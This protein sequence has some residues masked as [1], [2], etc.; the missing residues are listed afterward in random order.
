MRK[1]NQIPRRNFVKT[2]AKAMAILPF[3]PVLSS[4][5]PSNKALKQA[6]KHRKELIDLLENLIRVQ[7]IEG[8]SAANAQELVKKYLSKLPYLIEE[9]ADRPSLYKEHPEYMTPNPAGDGPFTNVVGWPKEQNGKQFAM[10]SHI[11][12]H[13]IEKGWSTD[14]FEPKII[15]NKFYGLGTSDDKAGVAA[16]LVSAT[17]LEKMGKPLPVVMS[18]HGKGGGGRGSLPVFERIRNTDHNLNAILYVHPAETGRGLDDIKNSVQG[19]ADLQLQMSGWRGTPLEIG[20]VDSAK[21]DDGGSAVDQCLELLE[22]LRETVYKDVLVNIGIIDGGDRIG[23][24]ADKVT[25]TFR[26][27]FSGNHTW[28][29]LVDDSNK[30]IKEFVAAK[31]TA[32]NSYTF[33]LKSVGYM[34]NPGAADWESTESKILRSSIT[35]IM[36]KEPTAYPNHYA[37]DIRYPI[38]LLGIPAYGIGSLGGNFYLPDEWVDID[39]LV[40]L[41]AVLVDTISG[42]GNN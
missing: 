22:I 40:K 37:G 7:S 18:L 27:K 21:W 15:G 35:D 31:S 23:S 2:S 36:G 17:I 28:K 8:E 33:E 1:E 24:V 19:I 38:R 30:V 26:L 10:F 29:A 3:L 4:I 14:P 11:D 16:M 20:S 12:T 42:W 5:N 13:S 6:E 34:T 9:S 25:V 39:D 32:E 41:V